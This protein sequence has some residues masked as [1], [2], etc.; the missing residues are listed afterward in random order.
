M[1]FIYNNY[2]FDW[3]R[4]EDS[5]KRGIELDPNNAKA[6]FAYAYML[7]R[8]ERWDEMAAQMETAISLDPAEPWW[9]QVYGGYLLQAHRFEEAEKQLKRAI[10][11]DPNWRFAYRDLSNL[12]VELGRFDEALKLAEKWSNSPLSMAYIYAR[13]G[14]RQKAL[15]FLNRSTSQNPF[16]LAQVY[17]ALDDFDNA[18]KVINQSLDRR[19]GFM[20]GYVNYLVLDKLKADPRWKD[21][22]RRMN[23]PQSH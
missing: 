21:V 14:N 15:D 11:I 23:L 7:A 19:E 20:F 1:C 9:I 3:S 22:A 17:A 8:V 12:Y 2:D 16:M 6:H 13:M 10:V 4:S 5:C 18:F